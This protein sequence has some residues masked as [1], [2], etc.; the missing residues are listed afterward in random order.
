MGF[1]NGVSRNGGLRRDA[2]FLLIG[3][4]DDDESVRDALGSL[5]RSAGYKCEVFPSAEAFLES[6]RLTATDCVV[7]DVQMP[8]LSGLELHL[9]L[10]EMRCSVPVIFVTG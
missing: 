2:T 7:L 9:R 1:S 6:G 10:R 5:L 8:G 4:I 3:V